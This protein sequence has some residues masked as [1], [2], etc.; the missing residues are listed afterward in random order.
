MVILKV[1][2]VALLPRDYCFEV[3]HSALPLPPKLIPLPRNKGMSLWNKWC[4][5]DIFFLSLFFE[6]SYVEKKYLLNL[7]FLWKRLNRVTPSYSAWIFSNIY[8]RIS[9]FFENIN[10]VYFTYK[11][12]WIKRWLKMCVYVCVLWWF[13]VSGLMAA[14]NFHRIISWY[15]LGYKFTSEV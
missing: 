5:L 1:I 6:R 3:K 7:N 13:L 14:F 10:K 2:W 15:R 8:A 9:W 4:W 12:M 11:H